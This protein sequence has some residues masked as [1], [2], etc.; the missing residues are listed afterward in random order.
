M[1]KCEPEFKQN[2]QTLPLKG[3]KMKW[4]ILSV[5]WTQT[6]SY[7]CRRAYSWFWRFTKRL[8]RVSL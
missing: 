1:G 2:W 7:T 5:P 4:P 8:T 3:K 6:G